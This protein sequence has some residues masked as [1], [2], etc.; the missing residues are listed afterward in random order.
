MLQMPDQDPTDSQKIDDPNSRAS[1]IRKKLNDLSDELEEEDVR[2][3]KSANLLLD[4]RPDAS[5]EEIIQKTAAAHELDPDLVR[6]VVK[7]ESN[8][9]PKAVSSA[10]AMG[11]MQLMPTTASD[12]G[13]DHPFDPAENVS[14]GTRYLKQMLQRYAGDVSQAL[15]AYNW[16]PG[17]LDNN[18]NS[19]FMPDETRNYI[20]I[21]TDY[22]RRFKNENKG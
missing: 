7:T 17:N 2:T 15:A 3:G 1:K 9:N 12:L 6:A 16:G 8:F 19:G 22:Y 13:V 11:L 10:G 4:I 21:V 5:I 18:R 14:G 20:R